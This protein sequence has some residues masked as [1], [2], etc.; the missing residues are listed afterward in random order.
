MSLQKKIFLQGEGD[1]LFLRNKDTLDKKNYNKDFIVHEVKKLIKKKN[2]KSILEIGC[3][4]GKR[5]SFIK[6]NF[7]VSCFGIDPSSKSLLSNN[8]KKIILK[9]GT[10][11]N[12]PFKKHKFDLIIFSFCLYLCDDG[13]LLKIINETFRVLK[14]RSFI[15]IYDFFLKD[16]KYVVYKHNRLVKSRKMDYSKLFLWHPKIKKIKFKKIYERENKLSKNKKLNCTALHL[17]KTDF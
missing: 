6:K 17:L 1:N 3:G 7:K 13:D 8:D 10:A 2:F 11:D 16:F 15:L 5:L 4:D 12:I 14:K 9:K